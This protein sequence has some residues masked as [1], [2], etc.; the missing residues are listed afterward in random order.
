MAC[1]KNIK[2]NEN[3]ERLKMLEIVKNRQLK[4]LLAVAG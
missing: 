2:S 1:A 3:F 4:M